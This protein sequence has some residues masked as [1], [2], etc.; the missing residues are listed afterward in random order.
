MKSGVRKSTIQYLLNDLMCNA[1]IEILSLTKF[2][3]DSTFIF[4]FLRSDSKKIV[5]ISCM[6]FGE[7][8]E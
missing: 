4:I 6:T 1:S 7:L 2:P 3:A 5:H 8:E